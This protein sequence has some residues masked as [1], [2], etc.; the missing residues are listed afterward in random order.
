MQFHIARLSFVSPAQRILGKLKFEG[1]LIELTEKLLVENTQY[2]QK[3]KRGFVSLLFGG[4]IFDADGR[5][6]SA[7]IGIARE[8][9]WP[10]YDTDKIDFF[11][12]RGMEYPWVYLL[13]DRDEQAIL[14]ER[15]TT[16]FRNYERVLKSIEDHLNKLLLKYGLRVF[17]KPLTEKADFWRAIRAYQ[18]IYTANFEL[19]M[20][21]FFGKTQN[22]LKKMLEI[23]REDYNATSAASQISNLDG[24]LR[25]KEDDQQI[26]N[27]L[28]WIIKGGGSWFL[29]G[30]KTGAKKKVKITSTRSENIKSEETSIEIENYTVE[31]VKSILRDLRPVYSINSTQDDYKKS[32][33]N[34]TKDE[35]NNKE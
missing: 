26:N 19:Y 12:K 7:K 1:T 15:N 28:D 29:E 24:R 4:F 27:N 30:I 3:K 35:Y 18:Y 25:I 22:E 33:T 31:E 21:N 16:V 10:D 32:S 13:W 6:L 34:D 8:R 2:T 11:D 5:L 17:V 9:K 20:P 14:I 23:L